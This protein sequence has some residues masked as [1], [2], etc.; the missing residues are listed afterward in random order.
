MPVP[1]INLHAQHRSIRREVFKT[2]ARIADSQRFV[3]GDFGRVLEKKMAD[4]TAAPYAIGVAS[5]SDA[6]FLSLL[7]LG[8]G[9][10]DEVITTPF[11]FFASAGSIT[12][13]G[14]KAVFCDIDP[15]HYNIDAGLIESKITRR[16]KAILPVHLFGLPCDMDAIGRIARKHNLFVVEDAAQSFGSYFHGQPTGSFGDTG[17]FSFY[18]TKNLGGAGDAGM[19]VTR[20]KTIA[21]KI[22]LLRNHGSEKKYHHVTVGMNSRLDEIQAAWLLVK[23]KHLERWNARRRKHAA[24]YDKAFSGLPIKTPPVIK[25]TLSNYHLYSIRTTRRDALSGHLDRL[26]IGN[27]VYYPLCLHLQPCYR[28]LGYRLGAFPVSERLSR[29]ILSLPMYAEMTPQ[30]KKRVI[31]G[32]LSFF[33]F[34][35]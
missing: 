20:S 23:L 2:L 21:R 5:G 28:S 15:A 24:D 10:G 25:N 11:T 8:V 14:A 26:G 31:R 18:P 33:G 35:A 19:V 12:R 30:D 13:T 22:R 4:Y 27:G 1:F 34:A 32:V 17:C 29:E 3:L 6:L 16:T 7:A 9:A